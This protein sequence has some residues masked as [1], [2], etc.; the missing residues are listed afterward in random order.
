M[1]APTGHK[2]TTATPEPDYDVALSFLAKDQRIAGTIAE[3]LGETLKVFYFPRAQ[4]ALPAT[5]GMESMRVPFVSAS[6]VVVV[7]YRAPWGRNRMDAA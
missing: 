3:R 5:D 7:L 6:R 4:E 2:S 1:S